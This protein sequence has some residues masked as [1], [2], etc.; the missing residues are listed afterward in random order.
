[1]HGPTAT[2]SPPHPI[3]PPSPPQ[4]HPPGCTPGAPR[5]QGCKVLKR[6][7]REAYSNPAPTP[8]APTRL[9]SRGTTSPLGISLS[10]SATPCK[11]YE[12]G[13]GGHCSAQRPLGRGGA[14]VEV[15]MPRSAPR[16]GQAGGGCAWWL[17]R[18]RTRLLDAPAG[19]V[20]RGG[21]GGGGGAARQDGCGDTGGGGGQREGVAALHHVHAHHAEPAQ[22][23]WPWHSASPGFPDSR[24]CQPCFAAPRPMPDQPLKRALTPPAQAR[25]ARVAGPAAV[26]RG[27]GAGDA[28]TKGGPH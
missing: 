5:P 28:A 16:A 22:S 12:G 20:S 27:G 6:K 14:W 21:G 11:S 8:A 18:A 4:L 23:H 13:R 2:Q 10:P 1:M 7:R 24:A 9:Y 19:I 3:P 25:Q 26:G 15:S 17:L